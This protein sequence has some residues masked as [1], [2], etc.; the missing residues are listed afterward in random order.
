MSLVQRRKLTEL[1]VLQSNPQGI[2]RFD[3]FP[4]SLFYQWLCRIS[5]YPYYMPHASFD[6]MITPALNS[7]S[8]F[9]EKD[10]ELR[11]AT[12]SEYHYGRYINV[13]VSFQRMKSHR[14]VGGGGY[15]QVAMMA[16]TGRRLQKVVSFS[17][18]RYMKENGFH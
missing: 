12:S 14:G 16:C 7:C 4:R 2:F 15:F 13:E 9:P 6:S 17:G 5:I 8:S 18:F 11:L 1:T 3:T 10:V